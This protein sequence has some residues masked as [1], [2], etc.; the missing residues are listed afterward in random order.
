M[1]GGNGI[2]AGFHAVEKAW[3]QNVNEFE[4]LEAHLL[5]GLEKRNQMIKTALKPHSRKGKG[6]GTTG[7]FFTQFQQIECAET[8]PRLTADR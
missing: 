2:V 7:H 6:L 3:I 8:I 4:S 1:N 5:A